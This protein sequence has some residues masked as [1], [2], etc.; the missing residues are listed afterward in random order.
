[1]SRSQVVSNLRMSE[2]ERIGHGSGSLSS[3]EGVPEARMAS[4]LISLCGLRDYVTMDRQPEATDVAC[5]C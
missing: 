2:F 3:Q 4:T 5:S 1:M